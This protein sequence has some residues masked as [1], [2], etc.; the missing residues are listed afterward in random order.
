ME[1]TAAN[2]YL[3]TSVLDTET[4]VYFWTFDIKYLAPIINTSW[5]TFTVVG[6]FSLV[7]LLVHSL[8]MATFICKFFVSVA[9]DEEFTW[10]CKELTLCY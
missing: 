8:V 9:L 4:M 7:Y 5:L 10:G 2:I 1:T 6:T 3:V